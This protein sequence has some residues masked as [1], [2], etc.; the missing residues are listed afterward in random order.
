VQALDPWTSE[1]ASSREGN[2]ARFNPL[3]FVDADSPDLVENAMILAEALVPVGGGDSSFWDEEAKAL[4]M[5]VIL[6]VAT[7]PEEQAHRHLP[8]VRDLLLGDDEDMD[9]LFERMMA[10]DNMAVRGAEHAP[11]R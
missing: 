9:Q 4:L 1:R 3:D 2:L 10:S 7:D 5:G 8:R 11:S 6:H